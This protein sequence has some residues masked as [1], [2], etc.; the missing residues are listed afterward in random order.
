MALK[1]IVPGSQT[2]EAFF[3]A[4]QDKIHDRPFAPAVAER[5]DRRAAGSSHHLLEHVGE[6]LQDAITSEPESF[7]W[8]SSRA[9]L[10]S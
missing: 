4:A 3:S 8:C 10:S 2:G 6:V 7:S 9:R 5:G 1:R